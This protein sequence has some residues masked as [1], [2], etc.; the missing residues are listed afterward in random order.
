MIKQYVLKTI[1]ILYN[2]KNTNPFTNPKRGTSKRVEEIIEI[3]RLLGFLEK[4]NRA[5]RPQN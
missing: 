4:I 2:M 3:D 1:K 5:K